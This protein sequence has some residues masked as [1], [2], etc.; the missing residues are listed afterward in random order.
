MAYKI[1]RFHRN[2]R[3]QVIYRGMSLENAQLHCRSPLT[4]KVDKKGELVWFDGYTQE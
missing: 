1:I 4:H 3:K 2:G